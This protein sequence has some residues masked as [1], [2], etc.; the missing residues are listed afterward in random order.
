MTR[1]TFRTGAARTTSVFG[2]RDYLRLW[3][4]RCKR[5]WLSLSLRSRCECVGHYHYHSAVHS[6]LVSATIDDCSAGAI[7][8]GC[9]Y[10]SSAI[11]SCMWS[12]T[13]ST[14]GSSS[15][16]MRGLIRQAG[17]KVCMLGVFATMGYGVVAARLLRMTM[18][19]HVALW[20]FRRVRRVVPVAEHVVMVWKSARARARM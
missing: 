9:R 14:I 11:T 12:R 3:Q 8:S 20:S 7:V 1:S 2:Q 17:C 16:C 19:C 18:L 15:S 4:C 5:V 6:R 10:H 13:N